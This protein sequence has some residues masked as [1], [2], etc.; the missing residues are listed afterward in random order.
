MYFI[1]RHEVW[2][3]RYTTWTVSDLHWRSDRLSF[4]EDLGKVLGAE[5]VTQRGLG[6]QAGG[7]MC[8][9]DVGDRDGGVADPVVDDR[10]DRHRHRVFGQYL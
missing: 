9:L 4:R 1:L 2:K 5:H 6:E 8:I 7:V 10:V 3:Y